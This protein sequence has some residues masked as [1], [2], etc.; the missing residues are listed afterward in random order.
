VGWSGEEVAGL[1]GISLGTLWVRLHRG[2]ARLLAFLSEE[3]RP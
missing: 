1:A 3:E 2:R